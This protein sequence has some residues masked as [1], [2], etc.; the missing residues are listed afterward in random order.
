MV[1]HHQFYNDQ[2]KRYSQELSAVKRQLFTSSMLRLA[3]FLLAIL[4]IYLCYGESKL[5]IGIL[6]LTFIL[7]LYLVS[8]HTD[9][10]YKKA[11][12]LALI[13][14]NETELEVGARNFQ[15]LADGKEYIDALHD[16]SQDLD[17]FGRG[18]FYQYSNRTAL[19]QGSEI[20]ASALLANEPRDI[21]KKQA[22]IQELSAI[23]EWRQDFS[24]TASL[25]KTETSYLKIINW[26]K[27]Y[28][29]FTSPI[30]KYLPWVFS[31]LSGLVIG[32]YFLDWIS[33]W[34]LIIWFFLGLGI[35]GRHLKR[36]GKLAADC[37]KVQSTFQQYQS[38][39]LKL[40]E[41]AFTSDILKEKRG[42]I[43]RE[44]GTASKQMKRFSRL[45]N[46]LDQR[47]N[48]IIGI[49]GN[50]FML[51][52]IQMCYA[53][54]QWLTQYGSE[55]AAWFSAIAFF[56]AYNTM[57]NFAFNHPAYN[58]PQI[59]D[60]PL[61]MQATDASHPMLDPEKSV[62][63]NFSIKD[64]EFFIVTGANMAGKSTFLRTVAIQIVM[65]N[66]GLPVNASSIIY[67]PIKLI[68]SMRTTDSLTDD[69]SYFFSELKRLKFIVD[70]IQQQRYFIVL[71]EILKG[72]N[73]TDK[74][75]G[76]RKF[77]DRLIASK[78][79]GIIATHD[80]SLCQAAE[81][82]EAVKNYYFDAEIKD[83]ELHFDYKFKQGVCKNMNASFL[84]KK[85]GIVN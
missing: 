41:T 24:A 21:L 29:P 60:G 70:K 84:L 52:D 47:N 12:L 81:D 77:I 54:E 33:G 16:F 69:E 68:T 23:A 65:A 18:S 83:D 48:I 50:A 1:D 62:T 61:I 44:N 34:M 45:L 9:L 15:S 53:I 30:M 56:D 6:V 46:G 13:R 66:T 20:Y 3:I 40:E 11:K 35:T 4:G 42:L 49:L 85:M 64:A 25:V 55:V 8:R 38:L 67:N 51:R 78:S 39:L 7:F 57:G 27:G 63:N 2:I 36:I 75:Q 32:S 58:F 73:S 22:A 37:S 26:M 28:T 71:D 19:Q 17:L 79:T 10:H 31:I 5:I 80:L 59:H 76:S 72:T 82:Y 74:A 14:I 43:I